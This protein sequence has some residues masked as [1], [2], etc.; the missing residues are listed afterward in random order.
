MPKIRFEL[1]SQRGRKVDDRVR[2]YLLRRYGS[3]YI[4]DDRNI[5]PSSK[6]FTVN[7]LAGR[8]RL[9]LEVPGFRD[10]NRDRMIH[11]SES[12]DIIRYEVVLTHRCKRLPTVG[13]LQPEQTRLLGSVDPGTDLEDVWN[14]LSDNQCATFYQVSLAMSQTPLISRTFVSQ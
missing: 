9:Q 6:R 2:F 1:R 12:S 13:D 4:R 14:D 8:H 10:Y 11:P 7:A 5:H 3:G